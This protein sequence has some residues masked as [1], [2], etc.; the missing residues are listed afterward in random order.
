MKSGLG[1]GTL[2]SFQAKGVKK[3]PDMRNPELLNK[4]C[5]NISVPIL[6]VRG[7]L[8]DLVTEVQVANFLKGFRQVCGC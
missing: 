4:L 5:S 1:I 7:K 6:L 8:S 2:C 3:N